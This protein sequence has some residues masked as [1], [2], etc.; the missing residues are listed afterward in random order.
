MK[1]GYDLID[2]MSNY[3]INTICDTIF[4]AYNKIMINITIKPILKIRRIDKKKN[5]IYLSFFMFKMKIY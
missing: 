5:E 3:E 1:Y 4:L 2:K